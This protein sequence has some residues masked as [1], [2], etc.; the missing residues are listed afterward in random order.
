MTSHFDWMKGHFDWKNWHPDAVKQNYEGLLACS[1]RCDDIMINLFKGYMAASDSEFIQYIKTKKDAHDDGKDLTSDAL[2]TLACSQQVWDAQQA[3]CLECQVNLTRTDCCSIAELQKIKDTNLKLTKSIKDK[4]FSKGKKDE[5]GG[6]GKSGEFKK[7]KWA[8]DKYAWKR[9]PPKEG[10]P[11]IKEV[12]GHTYHW[13]EEHM[14]LV[15]H[16][17]EKCKVKPECKKQEHEKK[18]NQKKDMKHGAL[19]H[20]M[21]AVLTDI[22]EE[23]K[24]ALSEWLLQAFHLCL[25][26]CMGQL[27]FIIASTSWLGGTCTADPSSIQCICHR[28]IGCI[29]VHGSDIIDHLNHAPKFQWQVPSELT[30]ATRSNNVLYVDQITHHNW[31]CKFQTMMKTYQIKILSKVATILVNQT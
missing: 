9:E 10:Q 4:K 28:H 31:K 5:K 18:D 22:E 7:G 30:S 20:A 1:Q 15:T 2:M 26:S 16:L 19:A 23:D 24:D 25:L 11:K 13:C 14:A 21:R 8:I 12:K 17:P 3:G 6:S 27:L 29:P